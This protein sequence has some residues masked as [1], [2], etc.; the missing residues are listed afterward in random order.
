MCHSQFKWSGSLTV[1]NIL[2]IL[3]RLAVWVRLTN[4]YL[5]NINILCRRSVPSAQ[6]VF[7]QKRAMQPRYLQ[8]RNTEAG[9]DAL[10]RR[11]HKQG[12]QHIEVNWVSRIMLFSSSNPPCNANPRSGHTNSTGTNLLPSKGTLSVSRLQNSKNSCTFSF[13]FNACAAAL[14]LTRRS[15]LPFYTINKSHDVA[16][17]Q[18]TFKGWFVRP[19]LS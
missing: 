15:T 7:R 12:R 4:S 10:R 11:H 19:E 6:E 1:C 8:S 9:G 16:C 17:I 5:L 3:S 2:V 18:I 13:T 14:W